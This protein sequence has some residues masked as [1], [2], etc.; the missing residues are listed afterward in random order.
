MTYD[1]EIYNNSITYGRE[2]VIL[3]EIFNTLFTSYH[4]HLYGKITYL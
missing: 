1:R 3:Y 4:I 2:I